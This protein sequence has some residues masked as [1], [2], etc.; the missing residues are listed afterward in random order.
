[1]LLR[2]DEYGA[3][4]KM[5]V[6]DIRNQGTESMGLR[7]SGRSFSRMIPV[8]P[9]SDELQQIGETVE[10]EAKGVDSL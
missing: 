1:V 9:F 2:K 10:T 6:I 7:F 8:I 3:V 4:G 5:G